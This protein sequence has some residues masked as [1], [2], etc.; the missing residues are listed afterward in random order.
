[1]D[2]VPDLGEHTEPILRSLGYDNQ[3][4]TALRDDGAIR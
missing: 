2:P 1:M 4:I 3:R